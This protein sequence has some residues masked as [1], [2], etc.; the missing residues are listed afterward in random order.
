[1]SKVET[2]GTR[3][4]SPILTEM[5]GKQNGPPVFAG[6]RRQRQAI[7]AASWLD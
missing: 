6:H 5:P 2:R 4:T 1:M 7:S 3:F